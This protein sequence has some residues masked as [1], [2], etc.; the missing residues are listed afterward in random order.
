MEFRQ[1]KVTCDANT[2]VVVETVGVN[3]VGGVGSLDLIDEGDR[4]KFQDLIA[5]AADIQCRRKLGDKRVMGL[6]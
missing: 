4:P 3:K 2:G 6:F 1:T 5:E